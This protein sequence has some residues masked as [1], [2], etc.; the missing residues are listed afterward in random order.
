MSRPIIE[1]QDLLV[2]RNNMP[3]L[4]IEK[5]SFDEGRVYSLIGPNGAGKSTLLLSIMGLVRPDRGAV[6]YRGSGLPRGRSAHQYRRNM[7]M[8]FQEPLLFTASVYDNVASGLKIRGLK[9]DVIRSS[10]ERVLELLGISGLARRRAGALS[11]GE[12]QRVSIARA[13]AV[14][15]EIL[16]M[17]EP[18]SS[19]DAPSR[20]S[21]I[22][23]LDRIIRDRGIT[24]VFATH[25]RGEAIRLADRIILMNGGGI[26]QA[27]SP[28]DI[29]LYPA[30]EFVAS[31]MGTETILTG[32]VTGSGGGVF[33]V[34][35]N[36][37]EI[38]AVGEVGPGN[39][40]TFCVHP[41]NIVFSAARPET[42]ARNAFRGRIVKTVSMGLF[43]KIYFDCG[44]TLVAYVTN[45][46]VE[47]MGICEGVDLTA[48]FKATSV[49]IIKISQ[50][51]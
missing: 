3:A 37:V 49:H 44:L 32:R 10:V 7:A 22:T 41:D 9:R 18:F 19:L 2:V 8:V 34:S 29:T 33:T 30:S 47:E 12:A 45:R 35:I 15:P 24:T 4:S 25:D 14:D 21:L 38:E 40:V 23:D 11:G 31:F 1:I 28:T 39:A 5:L 13:L 20:E 42:T 43:Q 16:L 48:S 46:S 36:G 26:V 6:L 51:A 27:G 17:D 50:P